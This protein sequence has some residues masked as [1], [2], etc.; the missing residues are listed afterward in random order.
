VTFVDGK[1][2]KFITSKQF[3]HYTVGVNKLQTTGISGNKQ[4]MA[5]QTRK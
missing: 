1:K 5:H 3:K 4:V 2:N